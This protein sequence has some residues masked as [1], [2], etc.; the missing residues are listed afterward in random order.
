MHPNSSFTEDVKELTG[1]VFRGLND[2][3]KPFTLG[4]GSKLGDEKGRIRKGS[5]QY[6]TKEEVEER[7]ALLKNS[8]ESAIDMV[9]TSVTIPLTIKGIS[10]G[11]EIVNN[12][13]LN[14]SLKELNYP[15]H[16]AANYVKLKE[17]YRVSEL[18][19]DVVDS[20]AKTGRLPNNYM[21]KDQAK[22]LG[23]SEGKALN[24]Y[25]PGKAIGG[26]V[27]N[28]STRILPIK[29]GRIWYEADVGIDYKMSRSNFKNPGY[30]ILY[31]SDGLI[32]GTYDHY[33]TVFPILP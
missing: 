22:V 21:T 31:S 18:A 12:Y 14:N 26:D 25:A 11:K 19:N 7:Q 9:V 33:E 15:A 32:Y 27:F 29:N 2:L 4:I 10:K 23:W 16:N 20:I 17:Q 30:R 1:I 24:N 13:K 28:N 3:S 8:L 6:G 5:N